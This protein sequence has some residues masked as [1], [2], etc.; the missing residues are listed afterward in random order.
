MTTHSTHWPAIQNYL[1]YHLVKMSNAIAPQFPFKNSLQNDPR[2][3]HWLF[4]LKCSYIPKN[5]NY[6]LSF[7]IE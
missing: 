6:G 7:E 4:A 3:K 5:G 2:L 1:R